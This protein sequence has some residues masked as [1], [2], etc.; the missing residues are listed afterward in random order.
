MAGSIH[1]LQIQCNGGSCLNVHLLHE[2]KLALQND[3]YERNSMGDISYMSL[4]CSSETVVWIAAAQSTRCRP[5][6]SVGD[7]PTCK[8]P[9]LLH[10]QSTEGASGLSLLLCIIFWV[11]LGG[12]GE[13]FQSV[14]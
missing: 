14:A 9:G 5:I 10:V 6:N 1:P 4:Q 3:I 2:E 12:R 7:S 11:L 8:V 13:Y